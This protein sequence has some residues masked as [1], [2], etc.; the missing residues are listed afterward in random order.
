M[1]HHQRVESDEVQLW[2]LCWVKPPTVLPDPAV[3]RAATSKEIAASKPAAYRP[4]GSRGGPAAAPRSLLDHGGDLPN[5][6]KGIYKPGRDAANA[7]VFSKN[8]QKNQKKR[9]NNNNSR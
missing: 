6:S 3:P 1:L 4:P 7:P 9:E 5:V 8:Q 2:Q